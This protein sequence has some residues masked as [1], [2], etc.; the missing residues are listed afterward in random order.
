MF[1]LSPHPKEV[2]VKRITALMMFALFSSSS[3]AG[4]LG[5]KSSFIESN[6]CKSVNCKH[7]GTYTKDNYAAGIDVPPDG[8]SYTYLITNKSVRIPVSVDRNKNGVVQS[9]VMTFKDADYESMLEFK[10]TMAKIIT[11]F[12]GEGTAFT[13]NVFKV[14]MIGMMDGKTDEVEFD[15]FTIYIRG[16]GIG[17]YIK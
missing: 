17:F 4:L 5:T 12:T 9:M 13:D 1:I 2:T 15:T 11:A 7:T 3:A 6:F 14:W 16:E 8:K 10:Q